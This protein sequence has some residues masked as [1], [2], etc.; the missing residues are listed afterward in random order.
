MLSKRSALLR[1]LLI[2]LSVFVFDRCLAAQ[3]GYRNDAHRSHHFG[4]DGVRVTRTSIS[5][6]NSIFLE[7]TTYSSGGTTADSVVL[8][9]VNGDGKLDLVFANGGV[10]VMLGNGNGTFEAAVTYGSGGYVPYSVAVADVNGDGKLDVV[11][12]NQCASSTVCTNGV[13]GVLLGNGDGTFKPAVIYGSGGYDAVSAAAPAIVVADVNGDGKPD[14]VV[15][16]DCT[17]SS[18]CFFDGN[19]GVLLGNGNGTFQPAATYDS[20]S[21]HAQS[22]AVA[23]LNGDGKLDV[24]V[25][26]E[27]HEC[28]GGVVGVL[29][30]NGNGTFQPP[31]IYGSGGFDAYSIA[32]GDV[33]G[34]G[35]PDLLVANE[36]SN[37]FNYFE[38]WSSGTAGV[39]L[40]NGDGTFQ[41]V[42]SYGLN[43]H[44]A[45][46]IA[47]AD[48]NGD[49]KLDLV[50]AN[51]CA[52]IPCSTVGG[53]DL[54]LGNGD[55]TFQP[56]ATWDTSAVI[57]N[58][59]AAG[60]VNGDGTIDLLVG[61]AGSVGV[62]LGK[63]DTTYRAAPT[64]SPGGFFADS[65]AVADVNG[66][67]KPDLIVANLC[68][69]VFNEDDN[70]GDGGSLVG[71]LL[72]NGNGTFQ[73]AVSYNTGG[74]YGLSVAVADVNGDGKPDL[75]VANLC[76]SENCLDNGT[77]MIGV[78]LGNGDGTFQSAVSYGSGGLSATSI[79][80]ADVNDDGKP[81]LLVTNYCSGSCSGDGVIGVLL[82]NGDGTFQAAAPYDSGGQTATSIAVADVNG[83]GKPDL[84]VANECTSSSNC[85]GIVSV[86]LGNGD[87][88]FKAA[89]PYN[90]GGYQARSVAVADMNGDGKL[91]LVVA[92][93]CAS[94]SNCTNAVIGV[95][96]G[97]GDGTFR[98]PVIATGLGPIPTYTGPVAITS[99]QLAIADFDGD[100]KLDVA[101]GAGDFLLLGNGDG[102]FQPPLRLGSGGGYGIA[103][104]DF[105]RDGKPDLAAGGVNILLNVAPRTGTT[106]TLA[107]TINPSVA[108]KPVGF[109]A[110]VSSTSGPPKGTVKF[111]NG[112]V[113]LATVQLRSGKAEF[114]T[115]R[116]PAG[117]NLITAVYL[118]N[119]KYVGST[120]AVLNQVVLAPSNTAITSSLTRPFTARP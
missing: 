41:P 75:L 24:V 5:S 11:V 117:S 42:I 112:T 9:D 87:G 99:D 77:G 72:G 80:V 114:T 101:S 95:L 16:N 110:I 29:L 118:G 23:D 50:V 22:V 26:N 15:A 19:I 78:L 105:N 13:L 53:V 30:G 51:Q 67:G 94:S 116:L 68:G 7:A 111:L 14:L 12:A 47:L 21:D 46:F 3:A 89:A 8:A 113:V 43:G 90:S 20:G 115:S 98:A 66:D 62:L 88:T 32:V 35:K 28:S 57:A 37:E 73:P 100:G 40:G 36:A 65:I 69:G 31:V 79:A 86:L 96:L 120:S 33:N 108:G 10:G 106:T 93:D 1:V 48:V 55:G 45:N 84:L 107:S 49:S 97:N 44:N 27:C 83:D 103:V 82:G 34:D 2:L 92:H 38:S 74:E 6:I 109:R 91:D 70:C 39:L 81:D 52:T 18:T 119:P 76:S 4:S 104:G 25:T 61:N 71:V 56:A 64:L 85:N 102:T 63:G 59:V 58:S 54:L 60:D 17:S